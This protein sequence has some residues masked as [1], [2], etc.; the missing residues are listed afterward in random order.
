MEPPLTG[1]D[2]FEIRSYFKS[3]LANLY[4]PAVP[5]RSALRT[6]N[7]WMHRHPTLLADLQRTGYQKNSKI[8]TPVQVG[9][10]VVALGKP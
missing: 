4:L 7:G 10:V 1:E 9:M 2:G 8:L 3:E 5:V 6:L